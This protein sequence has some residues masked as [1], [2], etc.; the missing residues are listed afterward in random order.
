MKSDKDYDAPKVNEKILEIKKNFMIYGLF[1]TSAKTGK[2]VAHMFNNIFLKII[3]LNN[4][5]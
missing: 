2:G 3:D 5:L 1:E 4:E